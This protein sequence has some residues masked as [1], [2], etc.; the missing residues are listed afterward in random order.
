MPLSP[1]LGSDSAITS[2]TTALAFRSL[3]SHQVTFDRILINRLFSEPRPA[4]QPAAVTTTAAAK[5]RDRLQNVRKLVFFL[6]LRAI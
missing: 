2:G 6:D 3:P 1:V 5:Q 4:G